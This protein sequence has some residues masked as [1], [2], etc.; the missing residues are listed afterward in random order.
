L[1]VFALSHGPLFKPV[2]GSADY[3]VVGDGMAC[4]LEHLI[5]QVNDRIVSLLIP[6]ST[7]CHY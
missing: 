4:D 6:A 3:V 7:L 1:I 2:I 5:D